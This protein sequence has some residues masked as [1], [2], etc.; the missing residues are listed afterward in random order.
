MDDPNVARK[1][2]GDLP[3]LRLSPDLKTASV[4]GSQESSKLAHPENLLG[5]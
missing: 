1:R 5:S 3:R 2:R 4:R